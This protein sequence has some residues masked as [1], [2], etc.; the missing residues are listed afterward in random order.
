M[1]F[2]TNK[3]VSRLVLKQLHLKASGVSMSKGAVN[4]NMVLNTR[5]E[6]RKLHQIDVRTT[7]DLYAKGIAFSK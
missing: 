7:E 5:L 6:R 3:T 1:A 2:K 4:L